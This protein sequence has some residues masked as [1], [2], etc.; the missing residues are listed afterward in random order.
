M[1]GR[2]V[3]IITNSYKPVLGGIQTVTSQLAESLVAKGVECRVITKLYPKGLKFSEKL[4]NVPVTRVLV[5]NKDKNFL[6]RLIN[7]ISLAILCLEF[8]VYRP[9][10][11]YVHFP[12]AFAPIVLKLR[13]IFKFD[14][15]S[16]FHGHDV[17]RYSDGDKN[18]EV[19]FEQ[20]RRLIN[21][22]KATT[23][24]SK[25][26]CNEIVNTFRPKCPV[27]L[28][29]N[30]VDVSRFL[31][32]NINSGP[33]EDYIF[34]WG[35]LEKIKGYDNLINAF[36]NISDKYPNCKL[37]IAGDGTQKD[38]LQGLIDS[39]KSRESI[40]LLG[41]MTPEN[42]VALSSNSIANIIPSLRESFGIVALEAVASKRPIVATNTGGLPEILEGS[43]AI[44]VA[45]TVRGLAEGLDKVLGNPEKYQVKDAEHMLDK[46]TLD[47]MVDNYLMAAGLNDEN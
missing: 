17:L 32:N 41:R 31:N 3:Y 34:T 28:V 20:Q 12:E 9:K 18:H 22:S 10:V 8:L 16:C 47:K 43:S 37:Y 21:S 33:E 38:E 44:L 19:T 46:F 14:I 15:I 45:P 1:S 35:R 5:F 11:I 6:H 13:R 29:Y 26:L 4:D 30:A 2:C 24:C 7:W 25:F 27:I 40:K 42:I 39:L 23:G 36:C